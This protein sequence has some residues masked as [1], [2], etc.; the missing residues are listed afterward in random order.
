MPAHVPERNGSR[1]F[2]VGVP[3]VAEGGFEPLDYVDR[4]LDDLRSALSDKARGIV[5]YDA[6]TV[7]RSPSRGEWLRELKRVAQQTSDLLIFYFVGHG[8]RDP[9]DNQLYL[10]TRDADLD[11][12]LVGTAVAWTHV[13]ETLPAKHVKRA[14]FILDCCNS[15]LA[16]EG[17]GVG[18]SGHYILGSALPTK[19]Q[20]SAGVHV[21]EAGAEPGSGA[22]ADPGAEPGSGTG[23]DPGAGQEGAGK[24]GAGKRGAGQEGAGQGAGKGAMAARGAPRSRFTHEIISAM[25]SVGQGSGDL[26][27]Q[28]LYDRLHAATPHWP[29][30]FGDGWGPKGGSSGDGPDIVIAR[31]DP[32]VS[33]APVPPPVRRT[34][35]DPDSGRD[36]D[37]GRPPDDGRPP[38]ESRSPWPPRLPQFLRPPGLPRLPRWLTDRWKPALAGGVALLLAIG[39]GAYVLLDGGGRSGCRPPLELRLMTG[40]ETR[41]AVSRA[42]AEYMTDDANRKPLGKQDDAPAGCRRANFTV[43]AAGANETVDAFGA[44][45]AWAGRRDNGTGTP[46]STVPGTSAEPCPTGSPAAAQQRPTVEKKSATC[47]DPLQDVGPQ[48][49]LLVTG[50]STELS[51]IQAQLKRAPGPVDIERLGSAGYSP[52]VLAI[53]AAL[54]EKLTAHRVQRTGSTWNELLAAMRKVAPRMP[55]LRP[56]PAT[57]GTGLQHTVG[58][59]EVRDG[60]F[61]GGQARDADWVEAQVQQGTDAVPAP[62]ADSLLC[63]LADPSAEGPHLGQAA[64]LVS[65]KA[66]ADFNLG[67]REG[68]ACANSKPADAQSRLLA[69]YPQ[70]VPAL[71]MPVAEVR[72][73][74]TLDRDRRSEAIRQ[75]HVWLTGEGSG[76]FLNGIVRGIGGGGEPVRPNSGVWTDAASTGVLRDAVVVTGEADGRTADTV[77]AQYTKT[78]KPGQV[79]FLVDVSGSMAEGGKAAMA[80]AALRQSIQ[81]LG[82]QDSYGIWSYPKSVR[83]PSHARTEVERGTPGGERAGALAWADSLAKKPM[84][85]K[86]AAVHE[87]LTRALRETRDDTRPLIVLITDG[88][89]RPQGSSGKAAAPE[90]DREQRRERSTRVL[91]LSVRLDGC[92]SQIRRFENPDKAGCYSGRPDRAAEKLA[93]QVANQVQGGMSD[94][95]P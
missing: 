56:D 72:W 3:S 48:P 62:D 2:L 60:Q 68:S 26:T 67:K 11:V 40:L 39:L 25:E 50:S 51:R 73:K 54:E 76:A 46:L 75:F 95:A 82:P 29:A 59:Y 6:V 14:V 89:N 41:A 94:E 83:Q 33:H 28:G 64:A 44:T 30:E 58:L 47:L 61:E 38:Y 57:S 15:G 5:P 7:L 17:G 13:L 91:V 87:V 18:E 21:A 86:G 63:A 74:G 81:R 53:P 35:V 31:Y 71:D 93:E 92:T 66:V 78:R 34:V 1:A 45:T 19:T 90:L 42:V 36:T 77:V 69:Y 49:D 88:D 4:N 84:V 10:M 12:N 8:Y 43:F 16:A 80:Q 37:A 79:L 20:P 22:G 52:L 55:L 65:E 27:M 23:A 85:A 32:P 24:E 70:G 9:F